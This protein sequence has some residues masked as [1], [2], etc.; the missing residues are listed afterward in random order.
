MG[1]RFANGQAAMAEPL[2]VSGPS[3]PRSHSSAGTLPALPA[4]RCSRRRL[5]QL[6]T[7]RAAACATS[8]SRAATATFGRWAGPLVFVALTA[9][10]EAP[11]PLPRRRGGAR[12]RLRAAAGPAR[13][14]GR[15]ACVAAGPGPRPPAR[16]DRFAKDRLDPDEEKLCFSN[17][18]W[19]TPYGSSVGCGS[20]RKPP[21]IQSSRHCATGARSRSAPSGQMTEPALL[22]LS[23]APAPSP[24]SAAS[25]LPS[26]AS[27]SRKSRSS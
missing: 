7:R 6:L 22:P 15:P 1:E 21:S 12:R 9:P 25:L 5:Q 19:F 16:A 27:R 11:G 26:A 2:R 13:P 17:W 20:C 24:S 8:H 10:T 18:T 4:S 3:A 23:D 14:S